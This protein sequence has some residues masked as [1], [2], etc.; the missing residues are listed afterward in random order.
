MVITCNPETETDDRSRQIPLP[1]RN[2]VY[3]IFQNSFQQCDSPKETVTIQRTSK[4]RSQLR[5]RSTSS[6]PRLLLLDHNVLG[7]TLALPHRGLKQLL[8]AAPGELEDPR[9]HGCVVSSVFALASADGDGL[10]EC[11]QPAL[12]QDAIGGWVALRTPLGRDLADEPGLGLSHGEDAFFLEAL[13]GVF[14]RFLVDCFEVRDVALV[15]ERFSNLACQCYRGR[16]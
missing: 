15:I 1:P 14:E 13:E 7:L 9:A 16:G 11:P 3:F 8:S 12:V 5:T 10:D 2:L 6:P 4:S